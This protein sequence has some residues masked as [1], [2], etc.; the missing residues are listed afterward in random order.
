MNKFGHL[1]IISDA[2]LTDPDEYKP[3]PHGADLNHRPGTAQNFIRAWAFHQ[4]YCQFRS[5]VSSTVSL[6]MKFVKN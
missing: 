6:W 3:H 4:D 1:A 5:A 2:V